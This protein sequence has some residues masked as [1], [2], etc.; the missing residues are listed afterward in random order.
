WFRTLECMT[1]TS[2][3]IE[4][5]RAGARDLDVS[6]DPVRVARR[7]FLLGALA[8]RA[9]DFNAAEEAARELDRMPAVDESS[10]AADLALA[11]RARVAV[12]QDRIDQALAAL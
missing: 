9:G 2:D 6:R 5:A 10:I 3:E 7:S 11:L 8:V 1:M 12:R 4:A